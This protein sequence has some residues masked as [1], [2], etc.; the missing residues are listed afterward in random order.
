MSERG[1]G[2]EETLLDVEDVAEMSLHKEFPHVVD[3]GEESVQ[4]RRVCLALCGHFLEDGQEGG[5]PGLLGGETH[6][7]RRCEAD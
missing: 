4:G 3:L 6:V 1:D 7:R 2:L 5:H